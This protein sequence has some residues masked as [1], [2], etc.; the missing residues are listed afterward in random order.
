MY[1]ACIVFW[2]ERLRTTF[3]GS[4]FRV[5]QRTLKKFHYFLGLI[6][7]IESLLAVGIALESRCHDRVKVIDFNLFQRDHIRLCGTS[8][9]GTSL[10]Y[11]YS[12]FG[13]III[14][15]IQSTLG[16]MYLTRLRNVYLERTETKMTIEE[17]LERTREVD[18]HDVAMKVM[19]VGP[20]GQ[21]RTFELEPSSS[22]KGSQGR[23]QKR[24]TLRTFD[25]S[26]PRM[27][28]LTSKTSR[29]S[30]T[31]TRSTK[32]E[33]SISHKD[34]HSDVGSSVDK[35]S[36]V[37]M[38]KTLTPSTE[39]FR[40]QFSKIEPQKSLTESEPEKGAQLVPPQ[41][42]PQMAGFTSGASVT[43]TMVS[44]DRA[45]PSVDTSGMPT[46]QK[47]TGRYDYYTHGEE[48]SET[49]AG[50]SSGALPVPLS[51]MS[52]SDLSV[53]RADDGTTVHSPDVG[54]VHL[55]V[56]AAVASKQRRLRKRY[57]F[58]NGIKRSELD[59]FRRSAIIACT[60]MFTT[61]IAAIATLGR[62]HFL[63]YVDFLL[64][65]LF[66]L[67][68]FEFGSP[69]YDLI[70]GRCEAVCF[71]VVDKMSSMHDLIKHD[72][73]LTGSR[74]KQS[75]SREKKKRSKSRA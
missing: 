11:I 35:Q 67:A 3:A 38:R 66:M 22:R 39:S 2:L 28:T 8:N 12:F 31:G 43:L 9:T 68:A 60:T 52:F 23:S 42:R 1:A 14:F 4:V 25:E 57:R 69:I 65:V 47:T 34:M 64:N 54:H 19:G 15:G 6:W 44:E 62:L 53:M 36:D 46:G 20:D 63:A 32:Q 27:S 70:F 75:K 16:Y 55:Q 37:K 7:A 56:Q 73:S 50:G 5:K 45:D 61:M 49:G 71:P 13:S 40:G 72:E 29:D 30:Q 51:M 24:L 17:L 48:A 33:S 59:Y 21:H 74:R 58:R 26:Q 10:K 41:S 18:V